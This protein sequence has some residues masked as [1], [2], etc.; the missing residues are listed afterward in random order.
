MRKNKEHTF[1]SGKWNA[2]QRLTADPVMIEH[3]SESSK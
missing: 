2:D 3:V 1:M